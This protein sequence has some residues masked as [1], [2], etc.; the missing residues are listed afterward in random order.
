MTMSTKKKR[1]HD[2]MPS[3]S[4]DPRGNRS[5]NEPDDDTKGVSPRLPHRDAPQ[6]CVYVLAAVV[7]V[8]ARARTRRTRD[9]LT[10]TSEPLAASAVP[11]SKR[12]VISRSPVQV[13]VSAPTP[14]ATQR[15][16]RLAK[17]SGSRAFGIAREPIGSLSPGGGGEHWRTDVG[18]AQGTRPD[19]S[20]RARSS[21]LI[22]AA[23]R[24]ARGVRR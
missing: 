4:G 24:A 19:S 3:Q 1:H 2:V 17:A 12:F 6:W 8:P 23:V 5:T 16:R 20:T 11:P 9:G 18:R 22:T 14:T 10:K 13:W 7:T 21:A 15:P